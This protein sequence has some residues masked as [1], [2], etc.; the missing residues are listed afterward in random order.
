MPRFGPGDS[1]LSGRLAFGIL[2][3]MITNQSSNVADLSDDQRRVLESVIGQPL[4]RDQVLHWAISTAGPQ[5]AAE[6][7]TAARDR[8]QDTF[9]K[10]RRHLDE[11]GVS[12]A[13]WDA[14]V[15]DAVQHVRSQHDE[16]ESS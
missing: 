2:T 13:E 7:R 9:A 8:L 12:Q 1:T 3:Q 5:T 15:D 11:K 6:K 14:A 4:H 10:V 16:C